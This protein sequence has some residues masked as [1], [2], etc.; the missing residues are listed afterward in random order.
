MISYNKST[1]KLVKTRFFFFWKEFK[2]I[3][4]HR[5]NW[6]G[7]TYLIDNSSLA[8]SRVRSFAEIKNIGEMQGDVIHL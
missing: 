5:F 8:P 2:A 4:L 6:L 7:S 1:Y 3:S